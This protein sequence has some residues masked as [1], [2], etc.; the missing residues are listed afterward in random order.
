VAVVGELLVLRGGDQVA[1]QPSDDRPGVLIVEDSFIA[2]LDL[3]RALDEAGFRVC[4]MAGNKV[5]ALRLAERERPAA[6]V[7]DLFLSDGMTG[8]GLVREL[9]QRYGTVCLLSTGFAGLISADAHVAWGVIGKPYPRE[10]LGG[11][12][13]YC[14]GLAA[15]RLPAPLPPDGLELL[16]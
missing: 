14:L 5:L 16:R 2:A 1:E 9:D 8:L 3:S 15:G 12:L 7:V 6:A 13:A 11:A 10:M 4:G